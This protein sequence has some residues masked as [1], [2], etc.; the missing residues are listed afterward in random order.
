MA[1][2]YFI[3]LF[4]IDTA[5]QAQTRRATRP[6]FLVRGWGLGTRLH[7]TR[8]GN[9]TTNKLYIENKAHTPTRALQCTPTRFDWKNQFLL[10]STLLYD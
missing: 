9:N 6:F 2:C 8:M 1:L 5:D 4:R 10:W 7:E 3:G